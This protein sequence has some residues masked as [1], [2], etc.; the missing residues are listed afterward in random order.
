MNRILIVSFIAAMSCA[1]PAFAEL[2]DNPQTQADMNYCAQY[3]Y[4][5]ADAELNDAYGEFRK[6]VAKDAQ[7]KNYLIAAQKAWIS[8][9]DAECALE[10]SATQGGSAQPMI[11]LNC[12]TRLTAARVAEFRVRLSCTEGDLTCFNIID[13]A[14]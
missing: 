1:T 10:G 8:F 6:L 3:S 12:K 7:A 14:D 9:R 2:C 5:R 4:T 11:I 13:A